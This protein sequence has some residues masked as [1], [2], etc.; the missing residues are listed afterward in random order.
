M[1]NIRAKGAEKAK[2]VEKAKCAAKA[3]V[4]RLVRMYHGQLSVMHL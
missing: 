1:E 2:G 4:N 3:M